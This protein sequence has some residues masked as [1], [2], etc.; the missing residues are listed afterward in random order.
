[1]KIGK[2]YSPHNFF[3]FLH[4]FLFSLAE[5]FKSTSSP[6]RKFLEFSSSLSEKIRGKASYELPSQDYF[7]EEISQHE[8]FHF[9]DIIPIKSQQLLTGLCYRSLLRTREQ[10]WIPD[11]EKEDFLKIAKQGV[12]IRLGVQ[13]KIQ[14]Q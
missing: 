10:C 5:F 4:F 1:M 8:N 2:S 7:S 14:I 11:K 12:L 9:S 3:Y 13:Q 6:L